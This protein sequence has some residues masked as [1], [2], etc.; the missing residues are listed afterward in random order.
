MIITLRLFPSD[1]LV[2]NRLDLDRLR[3]EMAA[4]AAR[5]LGTLVEARVDLERPE[6]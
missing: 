6:T 5:E 2:F 1:S 4:A 3:R